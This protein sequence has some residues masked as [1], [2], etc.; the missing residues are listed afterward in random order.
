MKQEL[1]RSLAVEPKSAH[2]KIYVEPGLK[3]WIQDYADEKGMTFS[4]AGRDLWLDSIKT[5]GGQ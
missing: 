4:E 3:Q 2:C 5:K 1:A